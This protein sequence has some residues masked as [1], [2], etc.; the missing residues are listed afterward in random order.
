[1]SRPEPTGK[2]DAPKLSSPAVVETSDADFERDVLER[3]RDMP[4]VVDFWATWCQPCRMLGP[5]LEQ[6]AQEHAGQLTLVKAETERVPRWATQFGV[7]GIPAV[8]AVRDGRV[9]DS[10]V[11]LL[12]ESQLRH[13]I[14]GILPSEAEKLVT[15]AR[16]LEASDPDAAEA[17][18]RAAM[19]ADERDSRATISLAA[20]LLHRDRLDDSENLL[21]QLEER[22][23][24]EP[25]AE[26]VRAELAIRRHGA[27]VG[28]VAEL[29]RAVDE[30]PGDLV[31]RLHLGAALAARGD[32]QEALELALGVVQ[33]AA[34][35]LRD[36]ARQ[37][38]LDVFQVL[39][40]D[41]ELVSEYRRR[42]ST[43]L[44]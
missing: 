9:V 40:G 4:V 28:D 23:F 22:G 31:A 29:R 14:A 21:R 8:Y 25:E 43:A 15:A 35:E 13:W 26:R 44:Y 6:V 12:T 20:F 3:S 7:S 16:A 41:S 10:F 19:L 17:H 11:G 33:A 30:A 42:L 2:P 5:L 36:Q 1:M 24:L 38:M 32:H 27:E 39:P 18:Y 34:G 37:V